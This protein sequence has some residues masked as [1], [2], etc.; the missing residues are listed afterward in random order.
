[1]PIFIPVWS[2]LIGR[3]HIIRFRS[4][5]SWTFVVAQFVTFAA[6]M[7]HSIALL[8]LGLA[9]RGIGFAGGELAWNLGHNDFA[10]SE[11]AGTYMAI[12]VTLT[13]VRGL[14]AGFVGMWLYAGFP[15]PEG[16][17]PLLGEYCFLFWA[18]ICTCGALGFVYLNFRL[19]H[20]TRRGPQESS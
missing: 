6:V 15:T 18:I 13:G 4:I 7:N 16:V 10:S 8:A 5:H 20:L 14:I 19:S 1:M 17:V 2:R 12:H 3:A 11:R 9:V